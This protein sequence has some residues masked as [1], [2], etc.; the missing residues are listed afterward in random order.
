MKHVITGWDHLFGPWLAARM[1]DGL[2]WKPGMGSTIG[3]LDEEKGI[4][5]SCLY[6]NGNGKS[7]IVHIAGEGKSWLNREFLWFCFYYPFEQLKLHK[8]IAPICSSNKDCIR[9]T[10]HIGF[11]L[12][13]TL[14]DAS[15]K[16]DI[17]LYTMVRA[18]CRWLSL[19]K[20][21]SGKTQSS[22]ST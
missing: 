6:E 17:L 16:G 13:A 14:K 19:R 5:A 10:E 9:W 18:N 1:P 8:I 22:P 7:I 21:L 12:E 15:P 11:L 3:L 2:D 4:L 20:K